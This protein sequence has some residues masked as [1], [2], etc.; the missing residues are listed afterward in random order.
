[1]EAIL[2]ASEDEIIPSVP[3]FIPSVLI[4]DDNPFNRD[5]CRRALE[6]VGYRT[7]EADSG[8]TALDLLKQQEFHML[9]LDLQM[10]RVSGYD[11]LAAARDNPA[12]KEMLIIVMTAHSPQ[13]ADETKVDADRI[14]FKPI[15][16]AS[17]A[18]FAT[19]YRNMLKDK[20]K[21]QPLS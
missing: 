2:P 18:T 1:M 9:L 17:F 21:H 14:M 16:I 5:V 11:V 4:V 12:N 13:V 7:T 6:F 8:E 20:F 19:Q 3:Q 15:D 10:P